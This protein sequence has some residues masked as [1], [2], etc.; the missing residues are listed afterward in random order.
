MTTHQ[1]P[2]THAEFDDSVARFRAAIDAA[3]ADLR[4]ENPGPQ[5]LALLDKAADLILTH[6]TAALGTPEG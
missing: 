1:R 5:R 2:L 6:L 4:G 3:L